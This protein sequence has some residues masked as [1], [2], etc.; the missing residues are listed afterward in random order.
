VSHNDPRTPRL[1]TVTDVT[2]L[3]AGEPCAMQIAG[4]QSQAI[5]PQS[6][7]RHFSAGLADHIHGAHSKYPGISGHPNA[8]VLSN[9]LSVPKLV[10]YLLKE[11]S[12]WQLQTMLAKYGAKL[13]SRS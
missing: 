8:D 13:D 5:G 11:F 9:G 1:P 2:P 12:I 3:R 4:A 6:F 7:S 10:S